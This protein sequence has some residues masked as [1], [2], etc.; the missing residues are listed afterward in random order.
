MDMED[1]KKVRQRL[2][3]TEPSTLLR[4][5]SSSSIRSLCFI[6]SFMDSFERSRG[7]PPDIDPED[8][9]GACRLLAMGIPI[10]GGLEHDSGSRSDGYGCS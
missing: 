6:R 7:T 3:L 4:A 9:V 5:D 10:I 1:E 8:I 2:V